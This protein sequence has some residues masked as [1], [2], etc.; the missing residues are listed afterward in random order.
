MS[1]NELSTVQKIV[2]E[3][4]TILCGLR[5]ALKRTEQSGQSYETVLKAHGPMILP[6]FTSAS[7]NRL[8][9]MSKKPHADDASMKGEDKLE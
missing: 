8:R 5:R 7:T 1:G 6:V 2:E 3:D 4:L 9:M